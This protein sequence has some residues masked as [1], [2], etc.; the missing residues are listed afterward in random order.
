MWIKK[1]FEINFDRK[2]MKHAA[3][4]L[5]NLPN[6]LKSA[7]GK[8]DRTK[9]VW[10]QEWINSFNK[11]KQA[12]SDAALLSFLTTNGKFVL[13]S[14]TNET[15]IAATLRAL[16]TN[17]L[18]PGLTYKL[19]NPLDDWLESNSPTNHPAGYIIHG[20]IQELKNWWISPLVYW[21]DLIVNH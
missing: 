10:S 14:D 8:N 15:A 4:I 12:F 13:H 21:K 9:I 6:L 16:F 2:F 5:A 17:F 19:D 1:L 20:F 7:K 11:S 3:D 18:T